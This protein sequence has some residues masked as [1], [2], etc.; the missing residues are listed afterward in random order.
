MLSRLTGRRM[1]APGHQETFQEGAVITLNQATSM[2]TST[3]FNQSAHPHVCNP[4]HI[5]PKDIHH[6][7]GAK[8]IKII[9]H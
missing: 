2:D 5:N 9:I 4:V 3:S 7:S 6:S 8:K 1:I